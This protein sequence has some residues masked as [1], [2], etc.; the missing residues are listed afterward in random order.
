MMRKKMFE[1]FSHKENL[2]GSMPSIGENVHLKFQ[3][4]MEEKRKREESLSTGM[5]EKGIQA[6][7]AKNDLVFALVRM[8]T[9]LYTHGIVEAGKCRVSFFMRLKDGDLLHNA[10]EFI[11]M[12]KE[13]LSLL[14]KSGLKG[15]SVPELELKLKKFKDS[16]EE[17]VLNFC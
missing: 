1:G 13:N 9:L 5:F 12:A 15:L 16:L 3:R 7:K 8:G 4:L 10:S 6:S 17:K 14:K 11:E 2:Y